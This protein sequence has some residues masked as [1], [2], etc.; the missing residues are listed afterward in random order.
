MMTLSDELNTTLETAAECSVNVT[1]QNPVPV[2]HNFTFHPQGRWS[3]REIHV[4]GESK[5]GFHMQS[6]KTGK[7]AALW[8]H[9]H[10]RYYR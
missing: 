7:N 10:T 5:R 6:M 1:K 3:W 2:F 8:L 4:V 9:N